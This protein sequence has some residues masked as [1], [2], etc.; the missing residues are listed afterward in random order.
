ML[1][2]QSGSAC[3]A[4]RTRKVAFKPHGAT[5]GT[6]SHCQINK[7]VTPAYIAFAQM[8]HGTGC[9][10]PDDNSCKPQTLSINVNYNDSIDAEVEYNFTGTGVHAGEYKFNY[11]LYDITTGA[12]VTG[13]LY[14]AVAVPMVN[15]AY[16][17]GAAVEDEDDSGALAQFTTPITFSEV[18]VGN[19]SGALINPQIYRWDMVESRRQLAAVGSFS[20][21]SFTVTWKNWD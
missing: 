3:G 6:I 18:A 5:R 15:V 20:N 1:V 8:F 11:L 14:T 17:G 12:Q 16:Q 13:S 2:R 7:N 9:N 10:V 4:D 21:G 19:S